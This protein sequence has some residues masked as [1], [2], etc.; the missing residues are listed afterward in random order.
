MKK[1]SLG[2]NI[3]EIPAILPSLHG[4]NGFI[5]YLSSDDFK[6]Q[7]KRDNLLSA[8]QTF[9]SN[10]PQ[11]IILIDAYNRLGVKNKQFVSSIPKILINLSSTL[12][13]DNTL[14]IPPI[15]PTR[16]LSD[17]CHFLRVFAKRLQVVDNPPTLSRVK[18]KPYLVYDA[19]KTLVE[20]LMNCGPKKA[21]LLLKHF[22]SPREIIYAILN[23]PDLITSIKG[24]G[25]E[26]IEQNQEMLSKILK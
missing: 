26:F 9:S 2:K 5:F 6:T 16:N 17:C 20:G 24:F 19:Q 13:K 12:S 14:Y 3:L 21:A 8:I 1:K 18:S 4:N 11:G 7:T 25:K 10:F 23:A 15:I 22:D